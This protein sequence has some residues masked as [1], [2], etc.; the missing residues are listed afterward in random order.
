MTFQLKVDFACQTSTQL[1]VRFVITSSIVCCL[2]GVKIQINVPTS[3]VITSVAKTNNTL[4]T[5]KKCSDSLA[6][7]EKSEAVNLDS[8]NKSLSLSLI[9]YLFP[10]DQPF[11]FVLVRFCMSQSM[12]ISQIE[13]NDWFFASFPHTFFPSAKLSSKTLKTSRFSES[14]NTQTG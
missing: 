1:W 8:A 6:T 12:S 3:Q 9:E 7:V 10:P 13:K 14:H 5:T 11:F 4:N 2:T